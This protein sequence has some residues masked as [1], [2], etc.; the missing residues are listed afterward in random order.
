MLANNLF[1][2]SS[3][4]NAYFLITISSRFSKKKS[5]NFLDK[6]PR[7]IIYKLSLPFQRGIKRRKDP[8]VAIT[9]RGQLLL[10]LLLP[11]FSFP[12]RILA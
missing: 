6:I 7:V 12:Q 1:S 8:D 11:P 10:L 2:L 3:F 4:P 5:H 9:G